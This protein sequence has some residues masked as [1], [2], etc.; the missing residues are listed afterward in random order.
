MRLFLSAFAAVLGLALTGCGGNGDEAQDGDAAGGGKP[1]LYFSA[2]PDRGSTELKEKFDRVAEALSEELGVPVEYKP[3]IDYGATV[4]MFK[5]GDV[6]LGWFGG[7]TGCQARAA[8]PGARA[9]AQG[10]ADPHFK[11]YFIAHKDTGLTKSDDFPMGLKGLT[12]TFG[13]E[14]STSGRLMPEHF[15]R[16]ETGMA[17][18]EFFK[19]VA[20][21]G[22]HDRTA[23]AVA[24]GSVQAGA[25]N[26][27]TYDGMVETG[28]S[29]PEV[30]RVVWV[31]PDY[32]DYNWTAHP[33]LEKLYG[34]GFIDKVQNVLCDLPK[35][36]LAAMNREKLIP[37]RN[38]DF[39]PLVDAARSLDLLR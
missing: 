27:K 3:A 12:F 23:E 34:E 37:A 1:T 2:I 6:H 29:D 14:R 13:S 32:V 16:Q 30:C 17:P 19:S 33:E 18:R 10:A 35:E 36:L 7:L 8:V 20:F 25:L 15:I 28:T 24:N 11:S 4:Q 21:S 26:F 39:K 5:N 38:A 9:I 22:A 31:T